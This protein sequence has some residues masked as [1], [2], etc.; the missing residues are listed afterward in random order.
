MCIKNKKNIKKNINYNAC[1]NFDFDLFNEKDIEEDNFIKDNFLI[2]VLNLNVIDEIRA[3]PLI[4]LYVTKDN[5][6]TNK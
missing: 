5:F 1:M 6:I 4:T 2:V 3:L